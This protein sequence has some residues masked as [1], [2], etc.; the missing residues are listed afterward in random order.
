MIVSIGIGGGPGCGTDEMRFAS[1]FGGGGIGPWLTS[2]VRAGK[3][4]QK[5]QRTTINR[6]ALAIRLILENWM[7]IAPE[8]LGTCN[9]SRL[10]KIAHELAILNTEEQATSAL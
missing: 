2:C 6:V 8:A 5:K 7:R 3:T 10:Q 1:Y 9:A 4:A